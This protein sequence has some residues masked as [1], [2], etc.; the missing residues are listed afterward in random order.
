MSDQ[1]EQGSSV[2]SRLTDHIAFV[3]GHQ[4]SVKSGTPFRYA[5]LIRGNSTVFITGNSGPTEF[6][7]P[8]ATVLQGSVQFSAVA[9]GFAL[10]GTVASTT[11]NFLRGA[12]VVEYNWLQANKNLATRFLVAFQQAQVL[13]LKNSECMTVRSHATARCKVLPIARCTAYWHTITSESQNPP[14][15]LLHVTHTCL[16]HQHSL[17]TFVLDPKNKATVVA[18]LKSVVQADQNVPAAYVDTVTNQTYQSLIDA[19][20]LVPDCNV[21]STQ[22]LGTATLRSRFGGFD[23]ANI[24]LNYV[25]SEASGTFDLT[26]IQQARNKLVSDL[27]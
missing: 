7:V 3:C 1:H 23:N 11:Q 8:S 24:N 15:L 4:V 5:D 14:A 20:G 10:L 27:Q 25:S 16:T 9:Q 17:Q 6:V 19:K 21:D 26:Y 13:T 12:V 22:L 2:A 18:Y